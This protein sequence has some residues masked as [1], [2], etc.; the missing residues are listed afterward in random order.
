MNARS[1]TDQEYIPSLEKGLAVIELFSAEAPELTLSQIARE[2]N[3]TPGSARRVLCTLEALGYLKCEE[4]RFSLT[5]RVLQLGFAY[6]SSQP[7]AKVVQPILMDIAIKLQVNCSVAVLD[8]TD[9]VYVA[10]ATYRY[11]KRERD[12]V[13]LGSRFPAHATS[14]GKV[15]LAALPDEEL[16]R[17][18]KDTTLEAFTPSTISSLKELRTELAKVREQGYAINDQETFLGLRSLAIPLRIDNHTVAALVAASKVGQVTVSGLIRDHLP[19]LRAAS[20][21]LA[22]LAAALL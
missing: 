7:L 8:E 1:S 2:L 20:D 10:R 21:R 5:P 11:I 17:R 12:Y 16:R 15:L 18:Y 14:P 4:N 13:A 19:V 9:V 22:Q 3:L 6:L